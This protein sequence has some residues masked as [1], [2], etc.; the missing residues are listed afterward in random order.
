MMKLI[1]TLNSKLLEMTADNMGILQQ[2][3]IIGLMIAAT[4]PVKIPCPVGYAPDRLKGCISCAVLCI[5]GSDPYVTGE[6]PRRCGTG[7]II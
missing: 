2:T 5:P 6:C 1:E 3:L 4:I 7:R